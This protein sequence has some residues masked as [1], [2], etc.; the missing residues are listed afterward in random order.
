LRNR[1]AARYAR[2]AA[3]AAG[4]I[5]LAVAGVYAER[6]LR[7]A[8]AV[9]NAPVAV[10]VT[11]QQQSAQFSF[12]KVEQNRTIFTVRAS[13][14]TQY[15]DQNRAVLEDVWITLYGRDGSRND[16]IHTRECSYEGS[17]DV[18]CE[19]DV[20]LDLANANPVP[21]QPVARLAGNL[22][23]KTSNLSF[24]RNTGEASTPA[25]VEFQF[26][27]GRGRGA[28]VSYRTSD[29]VV[30]VEHDV[31]F[32]LPASNQTG[33]MPVTASGSSLEIRRADHTVLLAG[34]ATVREGMRELLADTFSVD[35][36]ADYH[37]RR[38]IATGH[39]QIHTAEG[40]AKI[41][42]SAVQLAAILNPSGWVEHVTADGNVAGTRQTAVGTDRFSASHVE[43]VMVPEKNLIQD[44]TATGGVTAESHEGVDSHVLKTD[45]LRVTFST[46]SSGEHSG[47]APGKADQQHIESAET[48]APAT[49][50][51]S[52]ANDVMT[53]RAKKFVAQLGP[54]GHLDKL[55]GHAGVEVRR[56]T[57]NAAPQVLSSDE[58]IATFGAHGDWDTLD[59]RGNV[60]FQQAD[61]QAT[62]DHANIIRATDMIVLD[63]SPVI[64]DAMSRTTAANVVVNQKSGD[65]R[66]TGGVVSTYAPT[67]PADA[68]S[69]G[70]GNAHISADTLSGIVGSGHAEV[71]Y[72][73]HA[74]LWQGES[75]LDSDRIELWQDDKKLQAIGHVVAVF[76]Q[77]SSPFAAAP[78]KRT[79]PASA[80]RFGSSPVASTSTTSESSSG[81]ALWKI[82]APTLTYWSDQGKAH[83]EGGVSASS[84]QGSLDSR[85][86]DIFLSS[87]APVPV[88][89]G[90]STSAP[91]SSPAP[92]N[93]PSGRQLEKAV[94]TGGVV[95]RQ[96]DRRAMA[97]QA[98]YTAADGKFVLSGGEPT[99][100]D[101]S[102]DTTTGH[103]LT[104]FVASDTILVDSQEGSRTLTKHRVEK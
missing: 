30:R 91:K 57:G 56:Q 33:G 8:R 55:L 95:V 17:G 9:R 72:T 27:S 23:V 15:K 87:V 35:L 101:A 18:H 79:A 59:E 78:E 58:L 100:A 24:N 53:L 46:G 102:S 50:E 31:E 44:M 12:S 6:A 34:P 36:D 60:R 74:R 28:G 97:E 20:E 39:P 11:V 26:P 66:A 3:M 22:E 47:Q 52:S 90:A 16:N 41:T 42:I 54:G 80:P 77:V 75:V 43:F 40:G 96:G 61:R 25:P 7:R 64:S 51:S 88:N 67:G 85:T 104:F 89:G 19:G 5:A 81:N 73:G 65:L 13:R 70:S 71:V 83:L 45:A 10:P 14:A 68:L 76:S 62:A 4:L 84:D 94:A 69:L 93:V 92:A 99:I 32:D 21:G 29:S 98:V 63:G 82:L 86:L 103:S 1:E 2:W 37:A 38:F 49:I 48:L